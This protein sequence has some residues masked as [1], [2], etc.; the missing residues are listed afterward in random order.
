MVLDLMGIWR[1]HLRLFLDGKG[2]L[3]FLNP[4]ANDI[5]C[6]EPEKEIT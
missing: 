2:N 1:C 6:R 4:E 3:R 5:A